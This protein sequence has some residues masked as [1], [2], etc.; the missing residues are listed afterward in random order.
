MAR[1]LAWRG[2]I[3]W[4]CM[5]SI[6]AIIPP[7]SRS[8]PIPIPVPHPTLPSLPTWV[9][10]IVPLC[11][12]L[13]IPQST[14]LIRV[15]TLPLSVHKGTWMH[16]A[17]MFGRPIYFPISRSYRSIHLPSYILPTY[18][19][20]PYPP[21]QFIYLLSLASQPILAATPCKMSF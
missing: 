12:T 2:S 18:L 15:L 4:H 10:G 17:I 3:A 19:H 8:S 13:A 11:I 7:S 5:S 1:Y 20:T 14:S 6:L 9:P 21:P 16:T